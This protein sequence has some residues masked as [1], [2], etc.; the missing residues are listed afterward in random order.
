MHDIEIFEV[1][2]CKHPE[3]ITLQGGRFKSVVFPAT[4]ALIKH[5]QG[6][7]LFDTGYG[8]HFFQATRRFPEKLYALTTPVTLRQPLHSHLK[9][10]LDAI[11]ISHF[12]ADHIAGLKDFPHVPLYCSREGYEFAINET[13]SR[14]AK[15]R[16]GVLPALLPDDFAQRAIFIEDLPCVALPQ[17]MYPFTT[18]YRVFDDVYAIALAGHAKGHYGLLYKHTFLLLMRYGILKR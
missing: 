5:R 12:H 18:G 6:N 8:A 4:A 1:G 10:P 2:H 11:F 7:L 9:T 16:K 13:I 3:F 14:F 15:T 17:N